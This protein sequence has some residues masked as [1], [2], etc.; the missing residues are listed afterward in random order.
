M[1]LLLRALASTSATLE[2]WP[3]LKANGLLCFVAI[4]SISCGSS[5]PEMAASSPS[6]VYGFEFKN[7][8]A[9]VVTSIGGSVTCY[10]AAHTLYVSAPDPLPSVARSK[11]IKIIIGSFR[12]EGAYDI[13]ES[14]DDPNSVMVWLLDYGGPND[15]SILAAG[16]SGAIR[17]TRANQQIVGHVEGAM[18]GSA[19]S[20]QGNWVCPVSSAP[21]GS[22][23]PTAKPVPPSS[24][25]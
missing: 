3:L 6:V 2:C 22:A 13:T 17:V 23:S 15:Y 18:R 7:S 10:V 9:A 5:L 12:G 24:G 11:V 1:R 21:S 25:P 14:A 19:D 16:R 20:L 4:A 8:A